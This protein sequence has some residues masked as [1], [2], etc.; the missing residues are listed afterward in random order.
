MEKK[1]SFKIVKADSIKKQFK[2]PRVIK[3]LI[4]LKGE[5]VIKGG[6]VTLE[7]PN[8]N[9]KITLLISEVKEVK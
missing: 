2:N 9:Y 6:K 4:N 1:K 3:R 7:L 8:R 5:G